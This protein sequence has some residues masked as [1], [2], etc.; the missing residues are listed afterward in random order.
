MR[1]FRPEGIVVP[2]VTPFRKDE[3]LN[4]RILKR[5]VDYLVEGGVQALLPLG[6][7]G[8]FPMLSDLE[9]NEVIEAVVDQSNG[10]VPVIAGVSA[11]STELA[12]KYAKEAVNI[13]ADAI[14]ATGPYYFTTHKE[15]LFNHFQKLIEAVDLPLLIYNIPAFVGYNIDADI[16]LQLVDRNP[17]RVAGAKVTT[18]DMSILLSYL[19]KLRDTTSILTGADA[20]ILTA[21]GEGAAGAVIGIA[22]VVPRVCSEMYNDFNNGRLGNAKR[23]E[24]RLYPLTQSIGLGDFP[25][26]LK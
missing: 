14:V 11:P 1:R 3:S 7:S 15:G 5:F 10:R 12:K 22:N 19:Q 13:G 9:R 8:E 18:Y 16:V 6:T 25:S 23:T 17:G 2:M 26:A 24:K 20:L 4:I 21:L